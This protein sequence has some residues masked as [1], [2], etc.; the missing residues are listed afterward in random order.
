MA[1]QLTDQP[2]RVLAVFVVSPILLFKGL[3]YKDYFII[4][5]AIILFFWDLYWILTKP[6]CRACISEE[7]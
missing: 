5:F 3:K 2:G 1:L 4:I 7:N 6:P